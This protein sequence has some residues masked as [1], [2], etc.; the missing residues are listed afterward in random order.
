MEYNT[1][2]IALTDNNEV[3]LRL[4]T[5]ALIGYH[6]NHGIEGAPIVASVM[7]AVDDLEAK[8]ALLTAAM[9]WPGNPNDLKVISGGEDLMDWMIASGYDHDDINRVIVQLAQNAGLVT[10]D[11]AQR[12]D[13]AAATASSRWVDRLDKLLRGENPDAAAGDDTEDDGNP[14]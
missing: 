5:K 13:A 9:R 8:A 4:S 12:L 1:V 10:D 14:T 2:K 3:Q 11:E 7:N 6:K